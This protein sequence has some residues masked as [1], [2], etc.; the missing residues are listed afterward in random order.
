MYGVV[1]GQPN[2]FKL[3]KRI[4]CTNNPA[5]IPKNPAKY[6]KKMYMNLHNLTVKLNEKSGILNEQIAVIDIIIIKTGLTKFA[7]T[8]ASPSIIPPTI[9]IVGPIGDGTLIPASRINSNETSINKISNIVGNGTVS[10]AASMVKSNSV[11]NSSWWYEV[12]ATYIPGKNKAKNTAIIL[13]NF[14][15]LENWNLKFAS[16]GDDRK[17]D[18]TP[19]CN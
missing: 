18:K 15:I 10:R 8:A 5:A 3:H 9:P 14:N 19:W 16:S 11:G 12:T 7:L 1:Y 6:A 13:I 4:I 2:D 17:S